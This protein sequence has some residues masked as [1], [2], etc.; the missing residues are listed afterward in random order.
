MHDPDKLRIF[1]ILAKQHEP[2]LM[3]YI[4]SLI[5]DRTLAQ[6]IAQ[7]T[8]VIAYRK[9]SLLERNEMF[10]AWLRGI[11]RLEVLSTLRRRPAE[12]PIEP[13]VIGAMDEAFRAL[14]LGAPGDSWEDRFKLVEQC[15]EA[16][17]PDFKQVC[18]LHYFDE[19]K[20]REIA[21]QLQIALATVLKRLERARHAIKSCVEGRLKGG[22][23]A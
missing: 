2:M 4:L 22:S 3:A 10:P 21:D 18:Q 8:L 16:L 20:A 5:P 1:E 12:I 7:Q 13:A 11:A 15:F 19:R 6:D 23:Y 9:I 17:P 14:E